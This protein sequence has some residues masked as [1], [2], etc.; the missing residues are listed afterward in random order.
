MTAL[1]EEIPIPPDPFDQLRSTKKTLL[2]PN[3]QDSLR[4]RDHD[5][6]MISL[7]KCNQIYAAYQ[8]KIPPFTCV[9]EILFHTILLFWC[10]VQ[11]LTP[12][13]EV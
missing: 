7:P 3:T 13:K 2:V 5:L 6:E 8:V 1:A 11:T 4:I 10:E 9:Q 12:P